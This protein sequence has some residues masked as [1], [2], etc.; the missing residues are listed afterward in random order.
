[1]KD[2]YASISLVRICRLLGISRQA[3]YQ[4]FW[5]QQATGI[6]ESLVLA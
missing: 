4:H 5:Q 6:E 2:L 1:M 3:Y